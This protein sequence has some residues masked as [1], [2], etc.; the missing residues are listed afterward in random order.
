MAARFLLRREPR[1][2]HSFSSET[3]AATVFNS[4]SGRKEPLPQ[5]PKYVTWYACGPTV[6]DDAHLGHARTYV[7][8][9]VIRRI[10]TD[11]FGVPLMYAMG[12]T[13]VDDKILARAAADKRPPL[14]LAREYESR[15]FEDMARL[16]VNEPHV[17]LR[18]SEHIPQIVAYVQEIIDRGFAYATPS[19][20][21]FD[22]QR[23]GPANYGSFSK[24]IAAEE[25]A[26]AAAAAAEAAAPLTPSDNRDDKRDPRDFALWKIKAEGEN[27]ESPWGRGRPGW[28][29]EC[30]ALTHTHFGPGLQ[31]HSGGRDLAFPHHCNEIAQCEAHAG[32]PGGGWVPLWLHT[33][34]VYI[35]GRKMSKSLKNFVSVRELLRMHHADDLRVFC[36]QYSYRSDVHYA[37]DRMS[38]ARAIR[39]GLVRFV[40]RA[41]RTGT[42]PPT[43]AS[44]APV[45]WGA[46]EQSLF[47]ETTAADAAVRA[48]LRDDFDTAGALRAVAALA[49]HGESYLLRAE[50]RGDV[51][52]QPLAAAGSLVARTMG[53]LGVSSVAGA[54][55]GAGEGSEGACGGAGAA[56]GGGAAVAALVEYRSKVRAAA[57][58]A[59]KGGEESK[60]LAKELL[61]LSDNLR[62]K[63]LPAMGI[64]LEDRA[65]GSH[66]STTK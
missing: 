14:A 44:A 46:A 62:D 39:M 33:G 45:A 24:S 59:L 7:C 12:V 3:A 52:N 23:F 26:A 27:W 8:F 5:A 55:G 31:V 66:F 17:R 30:S 1:R 65:A 21:Y 53:L 49:A 56:G 41:N 51:P 16:G 48:A 43:A 10:L 63:T 61:T 36:L 35:K 13:D 29:I 22:V 19:G 6:Y 60:A 32:R 40:E 11:H 54:A 18:V 9:D 20:V 64:H 50:G 57:K 38:E 34:H 4:L 42:R 2:A 58:T 37:P 28:H 47:D 25:D 15:F